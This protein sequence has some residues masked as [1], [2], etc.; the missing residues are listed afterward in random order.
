MVDGRS[1]S[2]NDIPDPQGTAFTISVDARDSTTGI[3]AHERSRTVRLLASAS[4]KAE[5]F[6]K[7]GHVFPLAAR[8][9]GV[10]ERRGHTEASVDLAR[11]A[12]ARKRPAVANTDAA[13]ICEIMNDDGTMARMPDLER[14]AAMH[15]LKIISI[16]DLVAWRLQSEKKVVRRAETILPTANG[17][18]RLFGYALE[19]GTE[20]CA[21]L[22]MGDVATGEAALCRIHSECLTGDAFGS[23]RCDCGEQLESA[24]RHIAQEGRGVIVYLRQ[25]GR[26]IGLVNKLRAYELQDR[27]QDTVDA[28]LILGFPADSRDYR[29]AAEILR[30]LGARSVRLMT[31]NPEKAR[32]LETAGIRVTER[33]PLAVAP[34]RENEFYLA[35]KRDRMHHALPQKNIRSQHENV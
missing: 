9:G 29:A 14:F 18:F 17:T 12:H 32:G 23:Y 25:E 15:G 6:R 33:V 30:N 7:P 22:I 35:T 5:D 4:A 19:D 24:M 21:A 8:R 10:L 11:I 28:N 13:V 20:E 31:N 34:R 27:G 26:G 1:A 2:P 16:E 3:S